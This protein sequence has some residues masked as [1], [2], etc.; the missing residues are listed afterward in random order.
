MPATTEILN[1]LLHE[2]EHRL[3][4][5][6]LPRILSCLDQLSD[7][8]IWWRPNESSNSI[9][10]LVL[11]LCGNVR[12]WIGTG[13][14]YLP[15]HRHRQEEFDERRLLSKD[16][17]KE[18]LITTM[19]LVRPIITAVREEDLLEVRAVQ[20][21]KETGVTILIHVTE[22]FSYHTGQI[23]FITKMLKDQPLGFYEGIPLE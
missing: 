3:Y 9:G 15:D 1:A 4:E 6:S 5:E 2:V 12:Q 19:Q 11:H 13:L 8:Q 21:F 10:N 17:L 22:H 7:E 14:G 18:Q 23:A 20:T 16:S